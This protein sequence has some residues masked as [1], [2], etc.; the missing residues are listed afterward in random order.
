M[1]EYNLNP[2]IK[3]RIICQR[4]VQKKMKQMAYDLQETINNKSKKRGRPKKIKTCN[5]LS[6]LLCP[7]WNEKLSTP[8]NNSNINPHASATVG[9]TWMAH[10]KDRITQLLKDSMDEK[11]RLDIS[12]FRKEYPSEYALLNNYFGSTK[13]AL[14]AVGAIRINA[15][16]KHGTL[17]DKLALDML[18]LYKKANWSFEAIGKE[19]GVTRSMTNALYKQ[20]SLQIEK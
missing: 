5:N 9:A 7:N 4:K 20:L 16:S 3:E 19:Y 11:N 14:E 2:Q 12:K 15:Y 10:A 1:S 8:I 6:N 17:R 13:K 18:E